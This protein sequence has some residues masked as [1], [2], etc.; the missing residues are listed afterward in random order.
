[1]PSFL[2]TPSQKS[3]AIRYVNWVVRLITIVY[4]ETYSR[5]ERQLLQGDELRDL[6]K[7]FLGQIQ[8][9][10]LFSD[11]G[12]LLPSQE[13][14]ENLLWFKAIRNCPRGLLDL[15]NSKACR[16]KRFDHLRL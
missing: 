15:V 3:S 12:M 6:V 14:Q 5:I 11:A 9:G 16:G 4:V 10:E 2:L 8:S 7:G 1:M 13:D